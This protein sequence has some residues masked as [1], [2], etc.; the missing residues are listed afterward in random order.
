MRTGNQL[1]MTL[2]NDPS[3]AFVLMTAPQELKTV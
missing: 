1:L 2:P 3:A